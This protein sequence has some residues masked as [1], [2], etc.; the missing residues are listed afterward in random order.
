MN[1][2]I[3]LPILEHGPRS[4]VRRGQQGRSNRNERGSRSHNQ[5]T[6]HNPYAVLVDDAVKA[7]GIK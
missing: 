5:T 2:N 4:L 7:A 1:R 6:R 3:S